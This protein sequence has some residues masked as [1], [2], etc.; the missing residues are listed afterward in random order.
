M[1]NWA[2]IEFS[3]IHNILEQLET[4]KL[5]QSNIKAENGGQTSRKVYYITDEGKLVL[6]KKIKTIL[7]KKGKIIY[8]FDLGLANMYVLSH[9]ELIQSLELYLKSVE[10]RIYSLE[11]VLKIQEENNLPYNYSYL[12]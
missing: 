2:D 1:D 4:I 10:D 11:Y 6:K 8:P 5:V 12:Q 9:S 7:S 3:S